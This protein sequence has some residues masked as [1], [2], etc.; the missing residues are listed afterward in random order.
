M[1]KNE[2]KLLMEMKLE[3]EIQ[4]CKHQLLT[5]GGC[6]FNRG[7]SCESCGSIHLIHKLI[8]GKVDHKMS[9]KDIIKNYY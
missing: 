8:S 5:V 3:D 4:I 9:A 1:S 6:K 2:L 7:I